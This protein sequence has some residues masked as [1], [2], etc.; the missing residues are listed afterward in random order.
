MCSHCSLLHPRSQSPITPII[1]I[2][3]I[4]QCWSRRPLPGLCRHGTDSA[5][6]VASYSHCFL[7]D[8]NDTIYFFDG[9][10]FKNLTIEQ[11]PESPQRLLAYLFSSNNLSFR[12]CVYIQFHCI[13]RLCHFL[14]TSVLLCCFAYSKWLLQSTSSHD[15]CLGPR[16]YYS[17]I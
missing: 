15:Y 2:A 17:L 10:V 7:D 16:N 1:I 9:L 12:L 6:K 13:L 3:I 14:D 11:F 5:R 8:L 4:A